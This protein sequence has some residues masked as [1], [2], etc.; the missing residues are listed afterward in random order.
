MALNFSWETPEDFEHLYSNYS[1]VKDYAI[2]I[3]RET[4]ILVIIGY[5]FPLFNRNVDNELIKAAIENH[6]AKK[7]YIQD[8]NAIELKS[9]LQKSFAQLNPTP[10]IGTYLD[11]DIEAVT[12][13][14]QF[15]LPYEADL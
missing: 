7:I 11:S 4:D 9:V 5:S 14:N 1:K 6:Q 10:G 8:R 15:V 12:F 13:E 2:Q 3:M